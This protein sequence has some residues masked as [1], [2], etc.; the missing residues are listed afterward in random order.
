[1]A[2]GN[3]PSHDARPLL[4]GWKDVAGYLGVSVRTAQRLSESDGLPIHRTGHQKGGVC[5]YPAELD[6]WVT[7]RGGSLTPHDSAASPPG[8]NLVRASRPEVAALVDGTRAEWS[9]RRG[10]LVGS[11][12][13]LVVVAV[14]VAYMAARSSGSDG[15][16]VD[17]SGSTT[18]APTKAARGDRAVPR[19]VRIRVR[20]GERPAA[21]IFIPEGKRTVVH[22][23]AKQT[24]YLEPQ[25]RG[26][27]LHVVLFEGALGQGRDLPLEVIGT[28]DLVPS[29]GSGAPPVRFMV[30]GGWLELEWVQ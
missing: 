10:L 9:T 26:R 3:G 6:G 30:E 19:A 2:N 14:L 21:D 15:R 22:T 11:V 27:S 28:A 23:A 29:D 8:Q 18:E 4:R 25:R 1:M 12:A 5:A 7:R 13:A 17:G 24:L 16:A 20:V